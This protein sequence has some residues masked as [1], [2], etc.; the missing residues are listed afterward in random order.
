MKRACVVAI[1][2]MFASACDKEG[3][4]GE[5]GN[6][7]NLESGEEEGGE[8]EG[9]GGEAEAE[10]GEA[11]AEGGEA[12]AEGG[13]EEEGGEAESVS[14][15]A[16]ESDTEGDE[17]GT[18]G[19][20]EESSSGE[21]SGGT[22]A[23]C[24]PL[25]QDCLFAETCVFE[26]DVFQCVPDISEKGGAGGDACDA[27]NDCDVGLFCASG[28]DVACPAGQDTCCTYFCEVG[29]VGVCDEACVPWFEEGE[30]P[31]GYD[32]VGYCDAV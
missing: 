7:A 20:Y 21:E 16:G 1:S 13:E 24:D 8:E 10:G 2:I 26:D 14:A 31:P 32:D 28:D 6:G 3:N 9:E 18:T 4:L 27:V 25:L 23:L 15:S 11:E 5:G 29:A 12:E 30:A 19:G 17:D 22:P